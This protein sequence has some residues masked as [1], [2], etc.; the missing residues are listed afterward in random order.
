MSPAEIH[1]P[2]GRSP[3]TVEEG[4]LMR[5]VDRKG[6]AQILKGTKVGFEFGNSGGDI[7]ERRQYNIGEYLAHEFGFIAKA[8]TSRN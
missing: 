2:G 5:V 4:E 7:R 6:K 8:T 3:V 1:Y